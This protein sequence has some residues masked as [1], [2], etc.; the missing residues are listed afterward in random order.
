[1][2]KIR[3]ILQS[4]LSILM[5]F[6]LV[7]SVA[8]QKPSG[9]QAVIKPAPEVAPPTFSLNQTQI[10]CIVGD[11]RQ[12][13]PTSLP[14]I[15]EATLTWRSENSDIVT[16]DSNGNIEAMSEGTAK[17]IATYGEISAECTVKVSWDD[18]MPQIVSPAGVDGS[19]TIVVGQEYT[20][21]P[22]V[23]YRGKTYTDG[24]LS[25]DVSDTQVTELDADTS[26]IIGASN[27]VSNVTISGTWRGKEALRATFNVKVSGDIV[28]SAS[29][30]Q[31]NVYPIDQIS[32]YTQAQSFENGSDQPT[33]CSF[34]PTAKVRTSIDGDPTIISMND[35][36]D[37]FSVTFA[38]S[39]ATFNAVN[40]TVEAVSFGDTIAT[41]N[42]EYEGETY[43]KQFNVHL[44]RPI[45][46]FAEEVNFF[47]SC[48]GTLRDENNGFKDTTLKEFVYGDADVV[49]ETAVFDGEELAIEQDGAIFG[50]TGTNANTYDAVVTI[51]TDVEQFNVNM[52]VFGQYVY[53]PTDLDVFV[54]TGASPSLDVYVEL[55][56]D[57]DLS[58]YAKALHFNDVASGDVIIP[59]HKWDTNKYLAKGFMGTFDGK[60]HYLMNY[61]QKDPHGFF[62]GL[63]KCTIKNIGFVN[64]ASNAATFIATF[65]DNANMENV[66]IKLNSMAKSTSYWPVG[67]VSK[68]Y[69]PGGFYKNVFIDLE[70]TMVRNVLQ[71]GRDRYYWEVYSSFMTFPKANGVTPAF[72]NCLVISKAPLSSMGYESDTEG[73]RFAVAENMSETDRVAMRQEAW[74][75]QTEAQQNRIISTYKGKFTSDKVGAF[76]SFNEFANDPSLYMEH[77]NNNLLNNYGGLSE[78]A[79]MVGKVPGVRSYN[80]INDML[81]DASSREYLETFSS[82]FWTI[83]EGQLNWGKHP[84]N[85]QD[86]DVFLDV[87][88]LAGKDVEGLT[89]NPLKNYKKGDTVQVGALSCFGYIFTG[90]KNNTTGELLTED[91]GTWS[92][93]YSGKA[94]ILVAQ[95]IED[96]DVQI[97]SGIK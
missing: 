72:E 52:T 97:N 43:V 4:A 94:T 18:E 35:N 11:I 69:S 77:Y 83:I 40:K 74:A 28:L 79:S 7:F 44:E 3:K 36:P 13:A 41:I 2:K 85:L 61:N 26:T 68:Y 6:V 20:F 90:W 67:V 47:S 27:G 34:I 38:D 1:M 60:G 78:R 32:L 56:R 45:A 10:E 9:P 87:G 42:F 49:I 14:N 33:A 91:N 66:Y 84:A 82:E 75:A 37:V 95:W 22:T 80:S 50:I 39:R 54:R 57:L 86:G 30:A 92:F 71:E 62:E 29:D 55:A 31:D 19:F 46:D 8:C 16:V 48:K 76:P 93:T 59:N 51:G 63:S 89:L 5:A 88:T 58:N 53:E 23:V 96:P 12:L 17:V 21:A 73:V 15:G 65:A 24:Q 81:A 64:C 70:D 25:V